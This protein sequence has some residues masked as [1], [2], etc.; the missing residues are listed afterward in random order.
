MGCYHVLVDEGFRDFEDAQDVAEDYEDGFVAYIDGEYQ[1]R[2]GSFETKEDALRL[3][4]SGEVVGTSS[5]G[6]TVVETG[7]DHILF[8]YDQGSGTKLAVQP[9]WT[10]RG[11]PHLVQQL[12]LPG[13][14][15][16]IS[17]A[18]GAT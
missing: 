1:V 14:A 11:D 16:N 4:E 2:A 8:Q 10:E 18:P 13:A 3:G 9:E 5:Y 15:L 12:P 7:T 17:A 6:L